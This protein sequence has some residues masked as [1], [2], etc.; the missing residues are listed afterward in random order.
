MTGITPIGLNQAGKISE[1]KNFRVSGVIAVILSV[2]K[3]QVS[4]V[5]A[6]KM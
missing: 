1:I 4:G 2:S 6:V 3:F 5:I